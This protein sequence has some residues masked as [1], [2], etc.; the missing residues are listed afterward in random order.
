MLVSIT[1]FKELL[2]QALKVFVLVELSPD[3]YVYMSVT[4]TTINEYLI[5]S[6]H[7]K[8]YEVEFKDNEL[9]IGC[10]EN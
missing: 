6:E 9:F 4:K 8:T 2:H 5:S 10:K 7:S 1:D 3:N